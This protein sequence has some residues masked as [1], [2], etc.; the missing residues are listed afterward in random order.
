[1]SKIIHVASVEPAYS[2]TT[3][4]LCAAFEREW[5]PAL[6]SA[7]RRK[8]TRLLS[9]SGIAR[10]CAVVPIEVVLGAQG[11][12]ERNQLYANA[13]AQLGQRVLRRA[14]DESGTRPEEIGAIIT[15]SCTGVMIP[16]VDAILVDRLQL[17]RDVLRLPVSQMGCAGGTAGLIYA[18]ELAHNRPG[19]KVALLSLEAPSLTF[20]RS[21]HGTENLVSASIFADGATCVLVG[22]DGPGTSILDADMYHFPESTKLMGYEL[23]DE[24]FKIVLDRHVPSAIHEHL[25]FIVEPFLARSGLTTADI[26]HYVVHPGGKKILASIEEFARSHGRTVEDSRAVFEQRGNMSSATVVHVLQRTLM[27]ARRGEHAYML[28]FGPGFTAQSLLLEVG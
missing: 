19:R 17:P 25:P 8:A 10:R 16:S 9:S 3:E 27:H 23:R 22:D 28:A 7:T 13:M 4:E 5:F 24:G 21:D 18:R 11:L 14:L 12:R 1:M 26:A 20:M 15:T 2:Y 6:D